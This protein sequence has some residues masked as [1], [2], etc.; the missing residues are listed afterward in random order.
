MVLLARR[1]A[2]FTSHWLERILSKTT[3]TSS[4]VTVLTRLT[5]DVIWVVA[6]LLVLAFIGVPITGVVATLG[7]VGL[8]LGIAL[9]ES[10]GN[11]ASAMIFF[12]FQPFKAGDLIETGDVIGV[13][14]EIQ[15]FHT[16]ITQYD[17]KVV[18]IPNSKIERDSIINYSTTGILRADQ[19]FQISYSDD[20][21]HA[22][23]VLQEIVATDERVLVDP[24]P[25]INVRELGSNGVTLAVLAHVNFE[26]FW[27]IQADLRK[28]V[29]L[30]FDQEGITIPFPQRVVH[31]E[32][33]S[34][35]EEVV[36]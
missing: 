18:T 3:L 29:K 20:L 21:E 34:R 8:V 9:Q 16:I 6:I 4:M 14:T 11:F 30:R 31:L 36:V 35:L 26:N 28:A 33:E 23:A 32:Q 22:L 2:R 27:A 1:F 7:A 19:L 10:I 12:L 25:V 13:V 24:P 15:P 17:K 5:F